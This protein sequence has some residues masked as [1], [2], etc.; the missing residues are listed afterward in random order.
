MPESSPSP[1]T[2]HPRFVRHCP[3]LFALLAVSLAVTMSYYQ[4]E[5]AGS[6]GGS[7]TLLSL[8]CRRVVA[9]GGQVHSARLPFAPLS[10][11]VTQV[12]APMWP[13]AT[14]SSC[15]VA[16]FASV[17]LSS[18]HRADH[19]AGWE[20]RT[21]NGEW[22]SFGRGVREAGLTPAHRLTQPLALLHSNGDLVG[23]WPLERAYHDQLPV[24]L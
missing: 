16:P 3:P 13:R 23:R 19:A 2:F 18:P 5:P 12:P 24:D 9:A 22:R 7:E 15:C 20:R 6:G 11:V 14:Q 10:R 1:T 4:H 8:P 21:A 17:R